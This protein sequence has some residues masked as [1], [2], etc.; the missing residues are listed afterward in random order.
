LISIWEL[1]NLANKYIDGMAPWTLAKDPGQGERLH[2]VLYQL[3]EPLRFVAVLISP[4]MPQTAGKIQTQLGISDPGSQNL[5]SVKA[6]GGLKAGGE[7][8][9]G[10]SLF[11]RIDTKIEEK[12]KVE[13]TNQISMEEFQKMDLRVAKILAAETIKKSDKLLKLRVDMGEE[14]TIVAGIARSYKPE[15]LVGKTVMILANLQPAK[16]MG[17]ESQGMILAAE[18][19][20]GAVLATFDGEAKIGAKIR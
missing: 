14:R 17:V 1:I 6:W 7:V 4:F 10:E 8:R 15:E 3:L 19:D 5:S 16:L 9:K 2:T 12:E 11:P 20:N 13:T 18:G